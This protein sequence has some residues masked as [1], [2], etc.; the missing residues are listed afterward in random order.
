MYVMAF[1]LPKLSALTK[2]LTTPEQQFEQMVRSTLNI[3]LPPGPQSTLLKLQTSFETGR[4]PEIAEV[5]PAP[6]R[7][8]QV[9]ARIPRLPELPSP[10]E[11]AQEVQKPVERPLVF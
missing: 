1:E 9:L 7:V 5:I 11:V 2:I 6:P 4:A 3:E 8:E 10:I